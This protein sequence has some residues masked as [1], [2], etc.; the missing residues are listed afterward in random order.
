MLAPSL[1]HSS[2]PAWLLQDQLQLHHSP[3]CVPEGETTA[4]QSWALHAA[5][6]QTTHCSESGVVWLHH[7]FN[8]S[9]HTQ[10]SEWFTP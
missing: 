10:G 1:K 7:L 6:L 3:A 5:L 9:K 2:F 4:A 8:N